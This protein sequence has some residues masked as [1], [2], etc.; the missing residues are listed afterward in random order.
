MV[1]IKKK[2]RKQNIFLLFQNDVC[3]CVISVENERKWTHFKITMGNTLRMQVG[4]SRE[5]LFDNVNGILFRIV[6]LFNNS[7]KKFT[8]LNTAFVESKWE[9]ERVN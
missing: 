3:V 8:T 7:I 9:S 2:M 4:N 5:N 1:E 6:A